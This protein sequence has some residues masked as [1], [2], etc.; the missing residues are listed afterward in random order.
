LGGANLSA[1]RLVDGAGAGAG[2]GALALF[3]LLDF[4]PGLDALA[5]TGLSR[6]ALAVGVLANGLLTSELLAVAIYLW[7]ATACRSAASLE[8]RGL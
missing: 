5:V 1:N 6:E 4:A 3:L 7:S 8:A 2:A